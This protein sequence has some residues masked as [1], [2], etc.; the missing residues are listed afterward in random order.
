MTDTII[1]IEHYH[2]GTDD[3]RVEELELYIASLEEELAEQGDETAALRY[4]LDVALG[5]VARLEGLLSELQEYAAR[6]YEHSY[7]VDKDGNPKLGSVWQLPGKPDPI[8]PQPDRWVYVGNGRYIGSADWD[9]EG[10]TIDDVTLFDRFHKNLV[11]HP[12]YYGPD[13]KFEGK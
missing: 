6:N 12:D 13:A 1:N 7:A 11:P 3:S 5:T 4:D 2:A 10:L 9:E 8:I